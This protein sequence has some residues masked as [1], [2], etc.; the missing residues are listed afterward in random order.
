[1]YANF[2]PFASDAHIVIQKSN[3]EYLRPINDDFFAACELVNDG[4]K[5]RLLRTY[6][7]FG[8]GRITLKVH[9]YCNEVLAAEYE[10]TFVLI[11]S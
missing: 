10:G 5:E 9:C 8:K 1:M 7:K 2:K 11:Q 3:M 4:G 6:Q